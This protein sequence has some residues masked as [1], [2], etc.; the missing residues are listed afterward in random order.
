MAAS[1]RRNSSPSPRPNSFASQISSIGAKINRALSGDRLGRDSD[2]VNTASTVVDEGANARSVSRGRQGF[3]SSGRGG[4]GNIHENGAG[5]DDPVVRGRERERVTTAPVPQ[6]DRAFSIGR[7][8][9]GNIRAP[10]VEKVTSDAASS[11]SV[12][13]SSVTVAMPTITS[14]SLSR[15]PPMVS[16]GRG[17]LGNIR[18]TQSATSP[19]RRTP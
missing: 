16:T 15:G 9:F 10:S 8:G 11:K 19:P 2:S 18:N 5:Y 17:G 3:S 4:L 7:G 13:T 1:G 6:P 14:R 12:P